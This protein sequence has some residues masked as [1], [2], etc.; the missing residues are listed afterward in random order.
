VKPSILL[1]DTHLARCLSIGGATFHDRGGVHVSAVLAWVLMAVRPIL[2]LYLV[3]R[4][5]LLSGLSGGFSK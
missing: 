2:A 4:R 5:H 1:I 3:G